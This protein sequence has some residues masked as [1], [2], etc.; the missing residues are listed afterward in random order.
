MSRL[1]PKRQRA[2]VFQGG[3]SLGAY[4]AGVYQAL[5]EKITKIDKENETK[6][7]LRRPVFDIIAGT[8]IGA[9]NSA[10]LV[11]YV[12]ENKTWEGSSE[13]LNEFWDYVSKGS[14]VDII[15]GFSSWWDYWHSINGAFA[16][17]EAARRYYSS[18]EFAIFGVPNVFSPLS[19]E[20]DKKFCDFHNTWYRYDS[21][22]LK[23]SLERFAKFPIATSFDEESYSQPRLILVSVDVAEGVPVTFDSYTKE[24]GSRKSE[25]GKHII[26]N[27][28]EIGYEHIIRYDNGITADH[29]IASA[30]VPINYDYTLLEV[31]SYVP[32]TAATTTKKKN[33]INNN[34][35]ISYTN[36]RSYTK[37]ILHFW[38]GGLLSNTPLTQV[39]LLHR[40]YWF[41]VKG[42]ADSVPD[43]EVAVVNVHPGKEEIIPRDHDGVVNRNSDITFSDKTSNDEESLLLVSDYVDLAREL[44]KIAKDN[45]VKDEIIDDLLDKRTMYHGRVLRPRTFRDI[46]AGMFYI[47]RMMRINRKNDENT[48]S[49]KIFDFSHKT[50][51]HLIESGYKNADDPTDVEEISGYSRSDV[52]H[53]S[54]DTDKKTQ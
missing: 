25:Y 34:Q 43:L 48:I 27:G 16:S 33:N 46:L 22:P 20:P 45:G 41:R 36:H 26:E 3:G 51:K 6:D 38:D 17:G 40:N 18:K 37:S 28:N 39:M 15:P 31:E 47:D 50:I 2:L 7:S 54:N 14:T 19:P 24:D 52:L 10:I 53:R 9:I 4:E 44:I 32:S 11:S 35:S 49:N 30:S 12:K 5:Y 8:S 21:Q 42:L 29:V 23:R 13:R 1:I